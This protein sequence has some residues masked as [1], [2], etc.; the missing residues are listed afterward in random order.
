MGKYCPVIKTA[1][2]GSLTKAARILG[3]SQPSLSYIINTI[4]K[5]L[6]VKIFHRNQRGVTLTSDGQVMLDIMVQIEQLE[7]KL[8]A[9]SSDQENGILR[10]GVLP[11]VASQWVPGILKAFCQAFPL[12]SVKLGYPSS[13]EEGVRQVRQHMLDVVFSV[14]V[15]GE[16]VEVFPLYEDP[17]Y[18]V[19][20]KTSP[21]GMRSSVSVQEVAASLPLIPTSELLEDE[22]LA[23]CLRGEGRERIEFVPQG[24]ELSI[25]L[26][27]S[28]LGATILSGLSLME[29]LPTRQV[30]AVP[31]E[32]R[33]SR[34]LCL[35]CRQ[36]QEEGPSTL[37]AGFLDIVL[38]YVE[39]WRQE[40][41]GPK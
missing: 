20:S 16:G 27:E 24:N 21:L 4:E 17:Y 29:I 23:A 8:R 28:G 11:G 39:T 3:Y 1:E 36:S 5:E 18:L 25:S 22:A 38:S 10:V 19:V 33:L 34:K 26:V 13:A 40:Y 15:S 30:R 35:L 31:L 12:A 37:L 41:D 2:C 32:E 9:Q 6:G 7:A 14:A